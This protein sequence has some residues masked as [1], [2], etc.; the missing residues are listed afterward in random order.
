MQKEYI[1]GASFSVLTRSCFTNQEILIPVS[2][3]IKV[4]IGILTVC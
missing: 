2:V 4:I 1:I 3:D